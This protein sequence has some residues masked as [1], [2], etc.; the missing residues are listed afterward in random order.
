MTRTTAAIIAV[1]QSEIL[2][3]FISPA[4]DFKTIAFTTKVN[5]PS[6]SILI[7]RV[8]IKSIGFKTAFKKP[9]TKL[10]IIADLKSFNSKPL[11][12]FEVMINAAAE[13]IQTKIM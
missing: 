12:N 13:R 9:M 7:G 8:R 2:K 4:A 11:T 5:K 10:A 3:L 1:V 6:V